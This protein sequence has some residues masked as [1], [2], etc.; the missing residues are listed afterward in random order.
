MLDSHNTQSVIFLFATEFQDYVLKIELG[1]RCATSCE[2]DWYRAVSDRMPT[3][4]FVVG[5]KSSTHAALILEYIP[6]GRTVDDFGYNGEI[7]DSTLV[8]ITTQ[9][10]ERNYSVFNRSSIATVAP[11]R[12]D[13]E[14]FGG[15]LHRRLSALPNSHYIRELLAADAIVLN[16]HVVRGPIWYMSK[17][18][19]DVTLFR[20][21]TP[22]EIGVIHGDLHYGNIIIP[23]HNR[24]EYFLI[25]PNGNPRLPLEYD[26]GKILHSLRG[27]YGAIMRGKYSLTEHSLRN[28][29]LTIDLP[30]AYMSATNKMLLGLSDQL[31]ARA[32]Y[33]AATHFATMLPHHINR[34][35]E[36][37]ALALRSTELFAELFES[38]GIR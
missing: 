19:S 5:I 31:C 33:M 12:V 20:Y 11:E 38:L 21:L 35:T 16:N 29:Q 13:R 22:T 4:R 15:K 24:A 34:R 2:I 26:Y 37:L 23:S 9:A 28:Y 30:A 6:E 27:G 1:Q 17:I 18:K 7:T 25:D 14:Q 32:F 10:L 8:R 3:P 36:T